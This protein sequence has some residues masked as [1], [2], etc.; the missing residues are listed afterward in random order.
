MLG[1][2]SNPFQTISAVKDNEDVWRQV[3]SGT[4][5]FNAW[6]DGRRSRC[7]FSAM[8]GF[9]RFDSEGETYA[10]NYLQFEPDDGFPGTAVQAE[11][12]VRQFNGSLNAVHTY[13]PSNEPLA[14]GH[15]V[16][17]DLRRISSTK[18]ARA[19][20]YSRRRPRPAARRAGDQSGHADDRADED[21]RPQRSALRAAKKLLALNDKLSVS[22]HVRAERAA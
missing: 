13:T 18:I 5:R 1:T 8:G 4:V 11:G 19:T 16:A 3:G 12:L 17:D 7:Q 21:D 2:G 9:D 14:A 6:S 20:V 10:P 22:G 15:H